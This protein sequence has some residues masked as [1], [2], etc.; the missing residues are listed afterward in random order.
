MGFVNQTAIPLFYDLCDVFVLPSENEPWG[1]VVNEVMNAGKAVI[2]SD[3]VGAGPDLVEDGKNGFIVPVGNPAMLADRLKMLTG[4]LEQ[5]RVMGEASR[6]LISGWNFN[7]DY[8][9][10]MNALTAIVRERMR[11]SRYSP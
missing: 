5:C 3:Q 6:R 10:L 9:G 1:L 2:V 11:A 7:A 4:N 8:R